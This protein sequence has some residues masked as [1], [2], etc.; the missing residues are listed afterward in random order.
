MSAMKS[1]EF[2]AILSSSG[3]ARLLGLLL[4]WVPSAQLLAQDLSYDNRRD[5]EIPD[6]ST[7]RIGPFYSTVRLTE[8]VGYR[9]TTSSGAGADLLIDNR[10]GEVR[11]DGS[12]FPIVSRLDFRNYLVISRHTDLDL[13]LRVTYRYFPLNTQ[14]DDFN[15][16]LPEEGVGANVSSQFRLTPHLIG[17]VFDRFLWT[18][19]FVDDRG[20]SDRSGGRRYERIENTA[21]V[22][23]DWTWS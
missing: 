14:E 12:D 23:F 7:L 20:L 8:S 3:L 4:I 21:G 5:V 6:H 9:Y 16:S 17:S 15:V 19:D 1:S 2:R 22:D 10:R 13:S 18:T 11:S